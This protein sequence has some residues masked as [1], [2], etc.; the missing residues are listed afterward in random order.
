MLP[1]TLDEVFI[2][3]P[4]RR[5]GLTQTGLYGSNDPSGFAAA[6]KW[7]GRSAD[8]V[9]SFLNNDSWSG[10]DSSVPYE[11]TLWKDTA[12]SNI[13]SVPLTVWGTS[14]EQVATG[15]YNDHFL[16]AAQGLAQTKPSA[17]GNIYIRAGWE[18]NGS[19]MPWAAEGHEDAFVK[20]FQNLVDTFRSVSDKFKFVWDVNESDSTYNPTKAY[21]GDKYVD[22]VG[23]DTYYNTAWDST[24]PHAAFE[25]N[26]HEQYGLQWQQDFAAAHGKATAVSEWGVMTNEAGPYIQDMAAWMKDHNM[27]FQDYWDSN[28]DYHGMLSNG[29]NPDA[30]AAL[31][32]A[33]A[34]LSGTSAAQP[35]PA[36]APAPST[37]A[38]AP[39]PSAAP[40]SA[41]ADTLVLK[42][43]GD[44]YQ[45]DPHF[46][47]TVDGQQVGGTLTTSASHAA[48]QTQDVTLTGNFGA[49]AHDVAVQ[50]LDDA[51]GGSSAADRNLYVH[52]VSLDG[53]VQAGSTSTNTAG[54]NSNGVA[55]IQSNGT[56]T[57]HTGGT[58]T[59][60]FKVSG[61][62]YQGDPHFIVTVDGHQV[63]G[64]LTTSAS[65]ATGQTQDIT[66]TGNF[67]AGAHDV[68]VQFLDD[69]WGGSSAADRNLYVHQISLNGHT[70]AG[71]LAANHAGPNSNGVADLY[72]MGSADWH[73]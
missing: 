71:D 68:A 26:V 58:D 25:H 39:A 67:G 23:M 47:V 35:A 65:H 24:N 50:F 46:I 64:T 45:G 15:S 33:F 69:A 38:A 12:A 7:L 13:W 4:R 20:S 59:L 2:D 30:G 57:F 31:K 66:L 18:F 52:Q 36:P 42:V 73:L 21:P 22:V 28:A 51:W 37:P 5:H 56:A 32:Q 1:P 27:V 49:G 40:A 8:N 44:S 54:S 6:N 3:D 72:A 41:S 60:V 9:L 14:L 19:W 11:T 53:Q 34:A 10:F 63:G 55:N 61:D 48:D 70:Q 29:Q 17:D 16:K 62:S 43:S